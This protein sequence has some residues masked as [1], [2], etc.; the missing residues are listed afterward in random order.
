MSASVIWVR[1]AGDHCRGVLLE[2]RCI[3][4]DVKLVWKSTE[5]ADEANLQGC[6]QVSLLVKPATYKSA[7]SASSSSL[8]LPFMCQHPIWSQQIDSKGAFPFFVYSFVSIAP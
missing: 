6:K 5:A 2:T 4:K 7:V 3:T 8:S 1:T